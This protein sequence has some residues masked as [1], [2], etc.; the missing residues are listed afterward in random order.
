MTR[1]L[2]LVRH[3]SQEELKNGYRKAKN[4]VEARRWHLLWKVALGWTAS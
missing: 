4:M 3:L 2:E 1:K